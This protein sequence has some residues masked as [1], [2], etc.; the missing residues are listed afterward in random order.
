MNRGSALLRVMLFLTLVTVATLGTFKLS[1]THDSEAAGAFLSFPTSECGGGAAQVHYEWLPVAGAV[2]QWIEITTSDNGFSAG[3]YS[4]TRLSANDS[5]FTAAAADPHWP[6]FWRINTR[7]ASGWEIS[8]V[9]SFTPCDWPVLLVGGVFC[10]NATQARAELRWAPR[11]DRIGNQWL[12]ISRDG[13][14]ADAELVRV[15]PLAFGA[16]G[17]SRG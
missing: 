7:T 13:S 17:F 10:Q 8:V 6:H 15:G 12:E 16:Q 2:E 11:A 14:F 3:T 5:T 1:Q 9:N 4:S